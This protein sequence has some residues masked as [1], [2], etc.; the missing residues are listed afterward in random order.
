MIPGRSGS[1]G[2]P[3]RTGALLMAL[4][5]V[6]AGTVFFL[7]VVLRELSE[8][9]ELT[10]RA[11]AA[12]H[13]APGAEV[14]VAGVPAGRVTAV[15]FRERAEGDPVLVRAVLRKGA[16]PTIRRDATVS[17]HQSALLEPAVVAV[18]PGT[19]AAPFDFSDT[20]RARPLVGTGDLRARLDSLAGVLDSLR[21]LG[22]RLARR[23]EEGPGTLAALRS[24]TA[25]V[26]ELRSLARRGE[27]LAAAV[28]SGS[29]ARLA[30]D[31][32]LAE[33]WGRIGRRTRRIAGE[34]G[35]GAGPVS[36][37]LDSL[38]AS[39]ATVARRLEEGRGSLARFGSDRALARELRTMRARLDSARSELLAKPL[40]WL[41]FRLF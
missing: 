9:P 11:P 20:L 8:G 17:I 15:R 32:D 10:I 16:A 26:D 22:R 38:A 3:V 35:E 29:A 36:A 2:T 1:G 37:A 14:W 23:L 24:D 33:A 21:P 5:A 27:A 6:L 7:D 13:L 19:A 34:I 12:R 18:D 4:L 28:P 25:L 40:R 41:R 30:G 39:A 31:D